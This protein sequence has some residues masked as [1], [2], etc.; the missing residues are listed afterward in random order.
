MKQSIQF[1][2]RFEGLC[3]YVSNLFNRKQYEKQS[4]ELSTEIS[5]SNRYP[6]EPTN[7]Y[8]ILQPIVTENSTE[9]TKLTK[10]ISHKYNI[11]DVIV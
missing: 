4:T 5:F 10:E 2:R 1:R 6:S 3:Q 8:P 9:N 7:K 11:D